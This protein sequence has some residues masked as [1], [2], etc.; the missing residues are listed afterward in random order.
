MTA[1]RHRL[2]I[3]RHFDMG[4]VVGILGA[5][6]RRGD[7]RANRHVG[8]GGLLRKTNESPERRVWTVIPCDAAQ[9][10][11]DKNDR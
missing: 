7:Y 2:I 5:Q 3:A 11:E 9:G 1:G 4:I 8:I 10:S 6:G